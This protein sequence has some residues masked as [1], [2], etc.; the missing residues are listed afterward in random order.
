[1]EPIEA[2][3]YNYPIK[4]QNS[5]TQ[6]TT[7]TEQHKF[8]KNKDFYKAKKK[9]NGNYSSIMFKSIVSKDFIVSISICPGAVTSVPAANVIGEL[10]FE[11]ITLV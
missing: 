8:K 7:F 2:E 9:K 3:V 10:N 1:M 4:K 5:K 6:F 11:A